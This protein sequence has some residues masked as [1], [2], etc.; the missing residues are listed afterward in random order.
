MTKRSSLIR[1]GEGESLDPLKIDHEIYEQP[2]KSTQKLLHWAKT[3]GLVAVSG[4]P[5]PDAAAMCNALCCC[6]CQID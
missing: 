5:A 1:K 6:C 2:L 3:I 4:A